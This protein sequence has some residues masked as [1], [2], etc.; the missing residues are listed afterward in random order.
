MRIEIMNQKEADRIL[1]KMEMTA[2][3]KISAFKLISILL[4]DIKK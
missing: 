3:G 1:K 4:R 2:S